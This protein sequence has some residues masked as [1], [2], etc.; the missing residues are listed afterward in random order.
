M[1]ICQ[2]NVYHV[3]ISFVVGESQCLDPDMEGPNNWLRLPADAGK[4]RYMNDL[5]KPS[6]K[7][8]DICQTG[9][10]GGSEGVSSPTNQK[11]KAFKVQY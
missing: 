5:G 3:A 2:G 8:F 6:K 11:N 10:G 7:K 9:R 4:I 1:Y